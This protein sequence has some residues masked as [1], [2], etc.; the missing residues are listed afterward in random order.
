MTQVSREVLPT[1]TVYRF[2]AGG[3]GLT[4]TFLTPLLPDDLDVLSRPV[5]YLNWEVRAVD[6]ARHQVALY[7]DCSARLAVDTP[8]QPVNWS[9]YR[10]DGLHVLRVGSQ[11]QHILARA[12]DDMRVDW[13]YLYL[14]IPPQ[15]TGEDVLGSDRAARRRFVASGKLS[16]ADDL[17]VP[18]PALERGPVLA[19]TFD[20]GGVEAAPVG[21]HVLLAYDDLFGIEYFHRRLRPYWRRG[22][23]GAADLLRAA[24]K[25]YVRLSEKCRQFDREL[26]ADLER[27]GG[28]R[29]A[30]L[31]ALAYR[32]CLAAHKLAADFDGTPLYFSKENFSNGCI[33]TVDVTYP[34][35]PFFLLLNPELLKAQLRPVLEYARSPRWPFPFAPHDLGT[36][37]LANGQVYG[38]GEKSEVNQ[39]PVEESGNLLLLLA[40]LAR[41]EGNARFAL[42]YWPQVSRWAAYL[43][44]RGMD[45]ENQLCTDDFAGHLAHN[46]N[47]SLKALLAL[48]AYARLCEMA[49]KADEAAAYGRL[50]RE[51]AGRWVKM[52]D[53]G[54]HYRL[55]FDR[56]GTWSQKYNLV[57]DK[58]LDL[59]LF[60]PE[61]AHKEVAYYKTKQRRFGLPLDNRH[62]YAKLDWVVWTAVLAESPQDFSALVDPAY[63]FAR[64]SPDRVPLTDWYE[65]EDARQHTWGPRDGQRHGFQAR[66]VV[67]GVFIKLLADP[68]LARKWIARA[69]GK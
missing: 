65:T 68:A 8:D 64:Q 19:C 51:M 27:V 2:E 1:R 60:P 55:A 16:G 58:L 10:L 21:R 34:A 38:G 48:A 33:A 15:G 32:Q 63:E 59:K 54:D 46:T 61:V 52:A 7:L 67:G 42:R 12:G 29:Y 45:P 17:D 49:G 30:R 3:V 69:A 44:D 20:L 6:S 62:G 37:P 22:G 4:L 47:L 53:D 9:R 25:D 26:L 18:R 56:P 41:A 36:Y 11:G 39:M 35:A 24:D 50:A 28:G 57:W 66:S 13:G 40:A 23:R 5:T 43:R 14:A 31:A